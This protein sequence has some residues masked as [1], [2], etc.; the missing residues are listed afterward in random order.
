EGSS[1]AGVAVP[2][3]DFVSSSW[4]QA[5]VEQANFTSGLASLQ[6]ML[7][8]DS[9]GPIPQVKMEPPEHLEMIISE[10]Q[11]ATRKG[12]FREAVR[13]LA[14]NSRNVTSGAPV[15]CDVASSGPRLDAETQTESSLGARH[16]DDVNTIHNRG[17]SGVGVQVNDGLDHFGLFVAQRLRALEGTPQQAA[18]M[19][20]IL[21]LVCEPF[22]SPPVAT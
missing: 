21:K 12:E 10:E 11:D 2:S 9:G 17:A 20:A 15:V 13:R 7:Q 22:S 5:N 19:A 1:Q 16:A 8:E 3:G 14:S 4:V 18:L 6:A